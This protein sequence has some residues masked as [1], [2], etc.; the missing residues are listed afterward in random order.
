MAENLQSLKKLVDDDLDLDISGDGLD[1]LLKNAFL[2]TCALHDD[3]IGGVQKGEDDSSNN[4]MLIKVL[5][6]MGS[7]ATALKTGSRR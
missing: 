7:I 6:A 5:D 4:M 2:N 3:L 1:S